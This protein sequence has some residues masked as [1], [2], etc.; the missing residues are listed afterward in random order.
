MSLSDTFI[1][2]EGSFLISRVVEIASATRDIVNAGIA[3]TQ[4]SVYPFTSDMRDLVSVF[5]IVENLIRPII[6]DTP[7][8]TLE[9]L[10][11]GIHYYRVH[12]HIE[13]LA[14]INLLPSII[15]KNPR[16]KIIAI[17]SIAFH[18]RHNFND[19]ALRNRLLNGMSQI[20][21]NIA[22]KND[23]AVSIQFFFI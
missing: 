6:I 11:G 22:R 4:I 18:F 16:I 2:T 3:Q 12:D 5:C 17:D 19:M 13:Q 21:S 7:P 1:D 9:G 20:L 8:L 14:L 10:L 23:V 15:A